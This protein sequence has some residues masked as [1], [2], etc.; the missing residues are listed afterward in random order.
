MAPA[1]R[2]ESKTDLNELKA[3]PSWTFMIP[4]PMYKRV[5]IL[6]V[7]G[8]AFIAALLV[9]IFGGVFGRRHPSPS[10]L[11]G[12]KGFSWRTEETAHLLVHYE[13]VSFA[14][15]ELRWL[16]SE[17]E[18]AMPRVL[19]LLGEQSYPDKIHIFAVE[20]RVRLKA[21]TDNDGPEAFP[22]HNT[23]TCVFSEGDKT[24]GGH[25]IMHVI[26]INRWGQWKSDR[27]WL[28]E[29]LAVYANDE[30]HGHNLH[31][32]N[33]H[34]RDTKQLV[35]L[36]RLLANMRSYPA[37]I[38]YPESGSFVKFLHEHY[39][40]EKLKELWQAGRA[41]FHQIYGRSLTEL[42]AEWREVIDSSDAS[43]LEY[44]SVSH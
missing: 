27:V 5:V 37:P 3:V 35:S 16:T 23:V 10:E 13:A 4:A 25:E 14:E 43:G 15:K 7:L 20:S 41:D 21:L 19:E 2:D 24:I 32:L 9:T 11:L 39:G 6:A 34:L 36:D 12:R 33:K 29:G 1:P 17:H 18:L 22:K 28:S 8:L 31:A 30:W 40:R 44:S 38:G 26:S 42:E